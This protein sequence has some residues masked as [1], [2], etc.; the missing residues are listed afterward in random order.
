MK[1]VGA[2][3]LAPHNQGNQTSFLDQVKTITGGNVFFYKYDFS[4]PPQLI[5]NSLDFDFTYLPCCKMIG[6]W[7]LNLTELQFEGQEPFKSNFYVVIQP[8]LADTYLTT[9]LYNPFWD[10]VT[11]K[12][13]QCKEQNRV[14][15]CECSSKEDLRLYEDFYLKF[16]D[17]V[18]L[19]IFGDEWLQWHEAGRFCISSIFDSQQNLTSLGAYFIKF[20]I[21]VFDKEN[22]RVGFYPV[23]DYKFNESRSS[24]E[25]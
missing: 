21:V 5:F 24:S 4:T 1:T 22:Q 10:Y 9:N 14:I 8:N 16:D 2:I 19:R 11:T 25:V 23:Y 3:A 15:Y 12:Y 6:Y 13:K 18:Q 7:Q 20:R 17:K